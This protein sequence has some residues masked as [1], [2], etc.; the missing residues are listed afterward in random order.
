MLLQDPETTP[1]NVLQFLSQL[2]NQKTPAKAEGRQER[3]LEERTDLSIG[4]LII[5][6][7]GGSADISQAFTAVTKDVSSNGIGVIANRSI[8]TP[9]VLICVLGKSEPV[10]FRALI[11]YRKELGLGWVRIGTNVTGM[12]DGSEYPQ[13]HRFV[14]SFFLS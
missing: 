14:A 12:V 1:P 6:L 2:A 11:Q 9:R 10:L 3:R 4:I 5:P 8:S 7:N 13:L